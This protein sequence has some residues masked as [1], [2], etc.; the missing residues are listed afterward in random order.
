MHARSRIWAA[1]YGPKTIRAM[2]AAFDEAWGHVQLDFDA[3]PQ[4]LEAVR[5]RLADG[6]LADVAGGNRSV[7]TLRS[8]GLL[9]MALQ[10]RIWPDNVG[11][12][13][14]MPER[15]NNPTYW[16]S[17]AEETR[18]VAE[19]MKDP[20]CKRL[21]MGVAETYAELARRALAGDAS[22]NDNRAPDR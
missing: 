11:T 15:A 2:V 16:R 22:K 13:A 7:P 17:Y 20:D 1:C 18:I 8:A 10:Y 3:S 12:R 9:A 4:S 5:L 19:Q 6:V 21:L 14:N